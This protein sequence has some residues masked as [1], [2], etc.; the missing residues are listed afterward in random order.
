MVAI[1]DYASLLIDAGEYSGRNDVAHLF[2]RFVGLAEAKINRVLRTADMEKPGTVVLTNGDGAL[3]DDFLEAR[4]VL[5]PDGYTIGAWSL[6]ALTDRY[7]NRGGYPQ[8]YAVVG[9]TIMA[10]PTSNGSLT[11]TYYARI[12]GLSIDNP[13]NWLLLKAPDAYL[14]AL[15]EEIGIW[16]KDTDAVGAARSMKE[17]ALAGLTLADNRLRWGN[18][19][20]TLSGVT[21]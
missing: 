17:M 5:T 3:P 13:T 16:A 21:P 15:V 14:Y 9:S 11:M 8:G 19:Q 7:R 12:P 6:S 1:T 10:R 2:P 20:V 4:E 18:G